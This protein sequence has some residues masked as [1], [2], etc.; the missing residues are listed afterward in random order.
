M[1]ILD[2]LT[3]ADVFENS[4]FFADG[5]Y[6]VDIDACKLVS[7]HRGQHFVVEATV[8][9]GISTHPEAPQAGS[10]AAHVWK[11]SGDKLEMGR[12]TWMGFLC[13]CYGVKKEAYDDAT[14][15]QISAKVLDENHLGGSRHLLECHTKQT[16]AKTDFTV[17]SW[18]GPASAA[19]LTE[20]GVAA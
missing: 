7:G 2:K 15:K 16:K 13:A 20:F 6:I 11:V 12:N 14:W 8:V 18:R 1:G 3:Q 5:R 17:H 4:Q 10:R 19:A 9:A